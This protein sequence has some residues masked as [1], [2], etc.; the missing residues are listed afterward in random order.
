LKNETTIAF[1]IIGTPLNDAS[2]LIVWG[3]GWGMNRSSFKPFADTLS[4]RAAH[5][6]VDFPGFGLSPLPPPEWGTAQVADALA[7]LIRSYRFIKKIVYVGHSY[8]GRIGIQIASRHPDLIDGLFLVGSAGLPRKRSILK[9][10]EMFVRVYTFKTLKH[11]ALLFGLNV[12]VLRSKFGS[13]DYR[14]AGPLRAIF[15]KIISENLS[16]EAGRIK[17]PVYL[18]YGRH[19]TE[20]P[21]E[22]GERLKKIIPNATLTI[23]PEQDHYSV[24]GEGRHVVIKRLADFMESLV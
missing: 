18:V 15:V 13:P 14:S 3:H 21:P 10:M 19:D 7:E 20:T 23:L 4:G 2:M 12:E 8:G 17:C 1:E 22:I 6:L 9:K 16:E 24:L 5:M 11:L